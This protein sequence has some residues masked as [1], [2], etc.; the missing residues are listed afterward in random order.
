MKHPAHPHL[1]SKQQGVALL[2]ILLMV[3]T[4]T[5]LAVGLLT[6]QDR[7][8]RETNVL[9]RQD[10]SLQYALA[11]ESVV[12]AGL[13]QSAKLNTGADSLKDE[14]AKPRPPIPIEDAVINV[15]IIDQSGMFN[16]NNLYLA[17]DTDKAANLAYF[18]R[19]LKQVGIDPE[20]A[21]A[22]L[23]WEDANDEPT[24]SLGAESSFYLGQNPPYLAANRLFGQPEEL[25][26][27]RGFEGAKYNLIAPYITALPSA[28]KINVNTAPAVVLAALDD[29]LTVSDMTAFV[30]Q[31]IG[32]TTPIIKSAATF[33]NDSSFSKIPLTPPEQRNNIQKLIDVKSSYFQTWIDVN[34]NGRERFLTSDLVRTSQSVTAWQ[35]SF[36]PIPYFSVKPTGS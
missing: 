29:S 17:A 1:K 16:L 32:A 21:G 10:Q 31:R 2:T 30:T 9:L 5:I 3:V 4:A 33:L 26:K 34:S 19:L 7:M 28:S 12:G 11:G 6:R 35:R 20:S 23:D 13:M 27:V 24:G 18:K 22:V 25:R 8:L 36:A 14:W 15:R